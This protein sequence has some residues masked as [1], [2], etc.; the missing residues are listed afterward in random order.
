MQGKKGGGAQQHVWMLHVQLL[1]GDGG[2]CTV[3]SPFGQDCQSRSV[4]LS[5]IIAM[6]QESMDPSARCDEG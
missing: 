3:H 4:L 6:P 2:Q 5:C 1:T